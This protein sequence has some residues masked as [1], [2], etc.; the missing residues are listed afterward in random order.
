MFC[1]AFYTVLYVEVGCN[2]TGFIVNNADGVAVGF[3]VGGCYAVH[4]EPVVRL[5]IKLVVVDIQ[6]TQHAVAIFTDHIRNNMEQS[7]CTGALFMDLRKAFDTVHHGTLLDKLR[8]YGIQNT[9]LAWF[10]DYSF[11]IKQFV[12]YDQSTSQ[13]EQMTF[14]VPQGSIL[15]PLLFLLINEVHLVLEKCRILMYA[16]DTV[17][18][19]SER[20]VEAVEEVLNKEANLVGKWFTNNNLI[21]NL[22][23]GKTELVIYG[24]CQKPAKKPSCDVSL[25]GTP[26]NQATSYE[27]LGINLD[28]HLAMSMQ[29]DKMYKPASNR[30]KLLQRIRPNISP[31]VAE[32]ICSVMVRP[33]LLYCYPIYLCVG[34][35]V[36]LKLQSIPDR[37]HKIIVHTKNTTLKM[38]TLDQIQKKRVS[39]DVFMSLNDSCPPPLRSMFERFDHGND[40][41]GNSSRHR[42]PKFKTE[43]GRKTFAFQGALI[44]NGLPTD[45]RNEAYFVT[46]KRKLNTIKF[47]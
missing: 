32:K 8:C 31:L 3:S 20:S 26:I 45:L 13:V 40:T 11:N 37:A 6:T 16:D 17:I 39:I 4:Q 46:F 28:N 7:R 21:L 47:V 10:E 23:K 34:E 24:T 42:F 29:I 25:N 38:D 36:K 5:F 1:H 33:E 15:G 18:H 19:V 30:V 12:C 9:E 35:S 2:D 41:R 27:Y 43:A 22:N 14:G 44:F